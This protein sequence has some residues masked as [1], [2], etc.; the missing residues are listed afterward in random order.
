MP[1]QSGIVPDN[2]IGR[3]RPRTGTPTCRLVH[4]AHPTISLSRSHRYHLRKRNFAGQQIDTANIH[5]PE[6][7]RTTTPSANVH[8]PREPSPETLATTTTAACCCPSSVWTRPRAARTARVHIAAPH[9]SE[10]HRPVP[11]RRSQLDELGWSPTLILSSRSIRRSAAMPWAN[12]SSSAADRV[13][14][15]KTEARLPWGAGP[16]SSCVSRSGQTGRTPVA[17]GPLAP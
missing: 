14:P 2:P 4:P 5:A 6:R 1:R 11:D 13:D 7:L 15:R 12:G 3:L 16:G 17:W 8:R 9:P 10:L